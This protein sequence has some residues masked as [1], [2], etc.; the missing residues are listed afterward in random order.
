[1]RLSH[2]LQ[3]LKQV[4]KNFICPKCQK[5][6]GIE[7]MHLMKHTRKSLEIQ[8]ACPCCEAKSHVG[9]K[10]DQKKNV[11]EAQTVNPAKDGSFYHQALPLED[12]RVEVEKLKRRVRGF[13]GKD[14][15]DL[16]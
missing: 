5:H 3:I 2:L 12:H 8:G 15:K 10:I 7:H 6:Y 16:F 4:E 1:M 11:K 13:E 9:V 14:I